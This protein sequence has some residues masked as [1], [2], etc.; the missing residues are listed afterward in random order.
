MVE[1]IAAHARQGIQEA[2]LTGVHLGSY[3]RDLPQA[4]AGNLKHLVEAILTH[5]GH[6]PPAPEQPRTLGTGRRLL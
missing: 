4:E 6:H 5:T 2:V 1:E 3:G